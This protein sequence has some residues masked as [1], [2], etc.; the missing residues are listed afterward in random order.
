MPRL[1]IGHIVILTLAGALVEAFGCGNG[2]RFYTASRLGAYRDIMQPESSKGSVRVRFLG[3]TTL[4]F[5]D[6]STTLLSDGFFS[7]PGILGLLRL[8]P[9]KGRIQPALQKLGVDSIDGVFTMHTHYD[10]ALDAPTVAQLTGADL[11]GSRSTEMLGKGIDLPAKRLVNVSPGKELTYGRFGLT[12]YES[13]HGKP[14]RVPGVI[15]KP[16]KPPAFVRAWKG[17]ADYS[18][19]IR[20][21]SRNMLIHA[22]AGFRKGMFGSDTADVVYLGIGGM[23]DTD[24]TFLESYWQEVVRS[25]RAKR[26]IL[27]HWDNFFISLDHDLK[28]LN[29]PRGSFDRVVTRFIS[30]G[31]R[32]DV[33]V[34][35]PVAWQLTDPFSELL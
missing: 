23:Q 31:K 26:V 25:T 11:I 4:L 14:D 30:F 3:T 2:I 19:R 9:N 18:V 5:Q 32:D 35:L 34:L 21:G 12:F 24:S 27:V 7:R 20:H 15:R 6:D 1:R 13:V 17:D 33:E 8:S 22:S 29:Y 16:L 28:P 10:H